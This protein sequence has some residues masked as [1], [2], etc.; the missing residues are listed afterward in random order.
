MRLDVFLAERALAKSRSRAAELISGGHVTVGGVVVT[1]PSYNVDDTSDVRVAEDDSPYVSRGGIKLDGALDRFKVSVNGFICADI[2]ASTGGFTDCLLK[3]GAAHVYAIDSGHGQLAE[4]LIRDPRVTNIEG[5]NARFIAED[6]LPEKCDLAVSDLS[7]IS[8]KL[9]IPALSNIAKDGML[10]VSLIKPQFE[11][12]RAAIG[13]GGIVKDKKQ[14]ELAVSG[15]LECALE[16]GFAP[17]GIMRSPIQGGDGNTEFLFASV[18]G[19]ISKVTKKD[20]SEAV[21]G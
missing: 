17:I 15:V 5:F 14:H 18:F 10:Y 3:R 9:I 4:V 19:G 1:K 16:N 7:F 6:T 8:Q 2:G 11:C 20:I 12:G 21:Y 13:K